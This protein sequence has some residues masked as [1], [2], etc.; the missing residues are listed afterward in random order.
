MGALFAYVVDG[1]GE[2]GAE[3]GVLAGAGGGYAG[4]RNVAG[5]LE[6]GV[7]AWS[8]EG[9]ARVA[10][11]EVVALDRI[12]GDRR[13]HHQRRPD[14]ERGSLPQPQA[15]FAFCRAMRNK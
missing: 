11:L 9:G 5:P 3:E 6:S 13:E 14:P 2:G 7:E 8:G 12:S 10:V 1:V 4:V 15:E